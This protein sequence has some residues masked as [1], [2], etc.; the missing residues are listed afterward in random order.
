[1]CICLGSKTDF[2]V[3]LRDVQE[4]CLCVFK[5]DVAQTTARVASSWIIYLRPLPPAS[6]PAETKRYWLLPLRDQTPLAGGSVNRKTPIEKWLRGLGR[7]VEQTQRGQNKVWTSARFESRAGKTHLHP[8]WKKRPSVYSPLSL[9]KSQFVD[10]EIQRHTVI[11]PIFWCLLDILDMLA[12]WYEFITYTLI[13]QT[14][15]TLWSCFTGYNPHPG[16][17]ADSWAPR[18]C[19]Q[20]RQLTPTRSS[21]TQ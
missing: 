10:E 19:W 6:D 17:K 7:A 12:S 1:M 13:C 5:R 18:R 20:S 8:V 9:S 14:H 15:V 2:S 11:R 4:T 16:D 21:K 3:C